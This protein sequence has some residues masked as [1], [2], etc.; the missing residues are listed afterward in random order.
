MDL[1]L[2]GPLFLSLSI[3]GGL[4]GLAA[5][6]VAV[7]R[8]GN[9]DANANANANAA[10]RAFA[11]VVQEQDRAASPALSVTDGNLSDGNLSD[12]SASDADSVVSETG[13]DFKARY[14]VVE[15]KLA[16]HVLTRFIRSV[17]DA[18]KGGND[19]DVSSQSI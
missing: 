9:A 19:S 13:A 12:G 18:N 14:A 8:R 4:A 15:Q 1:T 7:M 17:A 2:T 3:V 6:A 16:A 5:L 11:T 10:Q